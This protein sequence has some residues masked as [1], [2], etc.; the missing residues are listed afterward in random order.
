MTQEEKQMSNHEI[1]IPEFLKGEIKDIITMPEP[2]FKQLMYRVR[3]DGIKD[4]T[5]IGTV[6]GFILG[7]LITVL[8]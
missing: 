6:R 7:A 1:D 3:K 5:T 4:G 2:D 8:I